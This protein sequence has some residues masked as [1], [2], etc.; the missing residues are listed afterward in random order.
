M[1]CEYSTLYIRKLSFIK[2]IVFSKLNI[3]CVEKPP[4]NV[5]SDIEVSS[6]SHYCL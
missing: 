1:F 3:N 6:L 2:I 4:E 5:Y